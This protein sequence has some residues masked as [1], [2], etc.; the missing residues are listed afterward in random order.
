[1]FEISSN[2]VFLKSQHHKIAN[3]YFVHQNGGPEPPSY[4]DVC[5]GVWSLY[6]SLKVET[7]NEQKRPWTSTLLLINAV[8][9]RYQEWAPSNFSKKNFG[10]RVRKNNDVCLREVP[11]GWCKRTH[12]TPNSYVLSAISH[13][14]EDSTKVYCFSI[15]SINSAWCIRK[16]FS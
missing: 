3:S 8:K 6:V 10:G 14:A 5:W 7:G 12:F 16:S 2:Q 11:P 13:L 15:R 1:M 4:T 9:N